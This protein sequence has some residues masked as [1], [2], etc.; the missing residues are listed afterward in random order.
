MNSLPAPN[1]RTTVPCEMPRPCRLALLAAIAIGLAT[2]TTQVPCLA[3]SPAAKDLSEI[4][5]VN[6]GLTGTPYYMA[7]QFAN[8]VKQSRWLLFEGSEFGKGVDLNDRT[9]FD[10][11]GNPIKL[12]P[13]KGYRILLY[14]YHADSTEAAGKILVEWRGTADIRLMKA[15]FIPEESNG[16]AT[17]MITGGRRSY[18]LPAERSANLEANI[19]EIDEADPPKE[20]AVWLPDPADPDNL[21]L[22]G[23]PFHANLIRRIER[24]DPTAIRFMDWLATN[25]NPEQD[26][27]DRR[28]PTHMV[29][30]GVLNP[31]SPAEGARGDRAT[32]A[33][34][35][36]TALLGNETNR[37]IWINIPHMATDDY[38]RK[39]AQTLRYGSDGKEPY[40]GPTENPVFPPL[41]EELRVW[42]EYSNEI[43]SNGH[44]FAQGDWAKHQ[45]QKLGIT[46]PVFNARRASQIWQIFQEVFGGDARVV[47]VA[48]VWTGNENYTRPFLEE[49][50]AYGPTL[51]P[52][53]TPDFVSP[54]TYFGNNIQ[55]FALEEAVARR[56]S[57]QPWFVTKEDFKKT[58]GSPVPVTLPKNDPWWGSDA[59]KE[60]LGVTFGEWKRRMF[61]GASQQGGGPDTTGA[62]GGFRDWLPTM[63]AEIFHP[64]IP[65]I[66]YEGGPS[67]YTDRMDGPDAEDDGITL[68]MNE[69]NRD[70]GIAEVYRI[71]L[72]L[73]RSKGLLSHGMFVDAGHWS[74]YGQ[75]GHLEHS[76]QPFE[77]SPKWMAVE[78]W[79]DDMKNIRPGGQP[80]GEAPRFEEISQSLLIPA[81]EAVDLVIKSTGGD[82]DSGGLRRDVIGTLLP[83]GM[84]VEPHPEDPD[85]FRLSGTPK[86]AGD[87]F[88]YLRVADRD[89]DA[90]W[91]VVPLFVT[92]GEGVI[93]EEWLSPSQP[94]LF[95]EG[96][97]IWSG[98][99]RREGA[100]QPIGLMKRKSERGLGFAQATPEGS[101]RLADAIDREQFLTG[102]LT[103]ESGQSLDLRGG[104]LD[105][106][107]LRD[108][109]HAPR[110]FAVFTSATGFEEGDAVYISEGDLPM[111]VLSMVRVILPDDERLA[112]ITEPLEIRIYPF[113]GHHAHTCTF[114]RFRLTRG[115]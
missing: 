113:G 40:T 108:G 69:L 64:P 66:S 6:I 8:S 3:E 24:L 99:E 80:I 100:A 49:L 12:E 51:T 2:C 70:P 37:D 48:G 30:Q 13:G 71:H 20:I 1:F 22:E 98:W 17:G 61:M 79:R 60:A 76:A 21:T 77:D 103:P 109:Y 41:K 81:G 97:V 96:G 114:S 45:A 68:F 84:K 4:S 59:M 32:G 111:S 58:D 19:L 34:W 55:G 104:Q 86:A 78:A 73:A 25:G 5:P 107:I 26:W 101:N 38:I 89:R 46:K 44:S 83:D 91:K 11:L 47:R 14:P 72:N 92:G 54:T 63:I 29:F 57:E 94:F 33:P 85:A 105:F 110:R 16:P 50:A 36:M 106:E 90:A 67:I 39:V 65:I 23:K 52:P 62:S 10:E 93:A 87:Y 56:H 18:H 75:W 42:V 74:K 15:D 27:S 53:V 28:L 95:S 43:W 112:K 31:R 35:E 7:A 115:H 82:R 9:R 102:T 88:V